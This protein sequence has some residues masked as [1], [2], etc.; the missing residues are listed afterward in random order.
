MPKNVPT[1][2]Q[3]H[4]YLLANG[5]QMSESGT[6]AYLMVSL[7]HSIRMLHKPTASDRFQTVFEISLAEGRHPADVRKDILEVAARPA[8]LQTPDL[9]AELP[10][11][12]RAELSRRGMSQRQLG[13]ELDITSSTITRMMRGQGLCDVPTF[14]RLCAWLNATPEEFADEL[15]AKAYRRGWDDCATSIRDVL[16]RGG[17]D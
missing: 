11:M 9:L 5:W 10:S 2:D 12:L 3:I 1:V 14:V 16:E 8:V 15:V 17:N 4:A 6:A 13:A 7:G